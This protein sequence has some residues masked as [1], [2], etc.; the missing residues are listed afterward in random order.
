M[1]PTLLVSA[2]FVGLVALLA[3]LACKAGSKRAPIQLNECAISTAASLGD[4]VPTMEEV[5]A[6]AERLSPGGGCLPP[7]RVA[8]ALHQCGETLGK[9]LVHVTVDAPGFSACQFEVKALR[10][11]NRRWIGIDNFIGEGAKFH[12]QVHIFESSSG[13]PEPYYYGFV[14]DADCNKND[15]ASPAMKSD[16]DKLE[17]RV[18]EFFCP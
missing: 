1:R 10:W 14:G 11:G 3:L 7:G 5:S 6:A 8:D 15:G 18:R 17:P 16:W 9:G 12:G 13:A 2:A 4:Y